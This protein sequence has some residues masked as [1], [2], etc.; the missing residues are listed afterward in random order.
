[1]VSRRVLTPCQAALLLVSVSGSAAAQ[2]S[3]PTVADCEYQWLIWPAPQN[4]EPEW[5]R[6]YPAV[7]IAA[8]RDRIHSGH[9]LELLDTVRASFDVYAAAHGGDSDSSALNRFRNELDSARARVQ[10]LVTVST[11]ARHKTHLDDLRRV[12]R[13]TFAATVT[14]GRATL[15]RDT[16]TPIVVGDATPTGLRR[17][18]CY[19]AALERAL[20]DRFSQPGREAAA[21]VLTN[22]RSAWENYFANGYS[23]L[24]WELLLNSRN[25]RDGSNLD[26]P[27]RQLVLLHPS[28]GVQ[29]AGTNYKALSRHEAIAIE[30]LGYLWYRDEVKFNK[31]VG[32]SGTVVFTNDLG[33][34][35]APFVHFGQVA[36]VGYVVPLRR[37]DP[38]G[39]RRPDG[40]LLSVDL[41]RYLADRKE[42]AN[43]VLDQ[44]K[45][46][47]ER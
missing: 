36:K 46:R 32:A 15:F 31:Y 34:G 40:L 27:R 7:R 29:V 23:Q 22:K 18:I 26:P 1:M 30:L 45:A 10:R 8:F 43:G 19:H 47:L 44:M 3:S 9:W 2:P 24:P 38:A 4:L 11:A 33:T 41:Y 20:L 12:G 17:T 5:R 14:A 28:V 21:A 39:A 25:A 13:A 35:V 6:I 42:M 37:R 16:Q